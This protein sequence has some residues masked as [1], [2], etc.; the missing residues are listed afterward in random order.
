MERPVLV[1]MF[2]CE[3]TAE[4]WKTFSQKE[5]WARHLKKICK[6]FVK[7]L[8]YW[9]LIKIW[10]LFSLLFGGTRKPEKHKQRIFIIWRNHISQY[11]SYL[12]FTLYHPILVLVLYSKVSLDP[13][14]F[15]FYILH[16]TFYILHFTWHDMMLSFDID[17]ISIHTLM[18]SMV[19]SAIWVW[20][21]THS[22]NNIG[23]RDASAS[24]K[25]REIELMKAQ[26]VSRGM[27]RSFWLVNP[28]HYVSIHTIRA[29][30]SF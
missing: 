23:L 2:I 26:H 7:D 30:K 20:L 1:E 14:Q 19:I 25:Q 13:G 12:W 3:T 4:D 18:D 9:H 28:M 5:K 16:F 8:K 22:V 15:T 29:F 24:K 17:T 27:R 6:T 11:K 21:L 10:K